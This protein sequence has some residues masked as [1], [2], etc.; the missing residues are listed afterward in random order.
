MKYN[1]L[2]RKFQAQDQHML[3][4]FFQEMN[5]RLL[6]GLWSLRQHEEPV[7]PATL[8]RLGLHGTDI[9]FFRRLLEHLDLD[10]AVER[11]CC[12]SC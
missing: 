10:I 6:S 12:S 1:H 8:P 9:R 5:N 7:Q 3:V 4:S 2:I 11:N